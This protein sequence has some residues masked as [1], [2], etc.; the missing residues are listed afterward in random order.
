M[1]VLHRWDGTYKTTAPFETVPAAHKKTPEASSAS[2]VAF[3]VFPDGFRC[4]RLLLVA[5]GAGFLVGDHARRDDAGGDAVVDLRR[6]DGGELGGVDD[7]EAELRVGR[8]L[9][10]HADEFAHVGDDL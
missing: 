2:G 5:G 9:A 6:I 8:Q 10:F 4:L 1:I 7:L 3:S